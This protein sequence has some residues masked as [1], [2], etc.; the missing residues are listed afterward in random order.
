AR[1]ARGRVAVGARGL[2]GAIGPVLGEL[3][4][5]GA[6]VVLQLAL[7]RRVDDL[8]WI[9]E[10]GAVHLREDREHRA[11]RLFEPDLD[12]ER[13]LGLDRLDILEDGLARAGHRAPALERG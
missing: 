11:R 8:L 6:D 12:A 4:R 1:C 3:E 5:S 10:R 7:A 2:D 9:D 13:G